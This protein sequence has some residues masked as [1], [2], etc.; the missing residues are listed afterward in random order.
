MTPELEA[1][2]RDAPGR[3]AR[4]VDRTGSAI[5]MFVDA[6]DLERGDIFWVLAVRREGL[7]VRLA[8]YLPWN[9]QPLCMT[10]V[11]ELADVELL[12]PCR[13]T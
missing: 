2:L 7:L 6:V 13:S 8:G 9:W 11:D 5:E 10:R 12:D 3:R 4:L 1:R